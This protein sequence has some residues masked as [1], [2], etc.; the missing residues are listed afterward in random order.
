MTDAREA[1]WSEVLAFWRQEV[2]EKGWFV[3]DPAVDAAC[4]ARFGDRIAQAASGAL[5]HWRAAPEGA[6]ALLILL[7]QMPR[8]IHR[9]RAE[10]FAHDDQAL[11]IA[12]EAIDRKHDQAIDGPERLF[13]YTP[14]EHSERLADQDRGV[15]LLQAA[16][17]PFAEG[18]K[19]ARLHREVIVRFGRFPHRNQ[20]LGRR[21]TA[22]EQAYLDGG[23][24][25]PGARPK[26]EP[27]A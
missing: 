26:E 6:L 10:A 27:P 17:P 2:G 9:G 7:D 22:E 8:N 20:A 21:M 15:A 5:D 25:A 12:A 14:F 4:A 11:Q 24:Y 16:G 13:F 18:L 19:H 23:G 1:D 3:S